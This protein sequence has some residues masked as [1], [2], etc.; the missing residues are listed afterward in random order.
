[1]RQAIQRLAL[2]AKASELS[3]GEDFKVSQKFEVKSIKNSHRENGSTFIPGRGQNKCELR[4]N[5]WSMTFAS[6]RR[7]KDT[8][9]KVPDSTT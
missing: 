1:M 7:D 5:K 6:S 8:P 2:V 9:G 3:L 4:I